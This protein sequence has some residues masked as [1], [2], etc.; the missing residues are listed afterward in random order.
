MKS[1][2][3]NSPFLY[4]YCAVE[5]AIAARGV[6]KLPH[7][8]QGS[9]PRPVAL[10]DRI[11]LIV[12]DVPAGE[13]EPQRVEARLT[14]LDWVSR[15]GAAHHAVAD[16]LATKHTVVPFR[17]FTLFSSEQRARS[18]LATK[19]RSIQAA[20]DRVRGK[21]EWVLRIGKPDPARAQSTPDT[22]RLATAASGTSFLAQK[23]AANRAKT[24]L[25]VRVRDDVVRV[26]DALTDV[27]DAARQ[28]PLDQ[29]TGAVLDAAFL[30]PARQTASFKRALQQ[31]ADGLL[32][33]G[34]RV[35]L[36]GPWPPYS[37]VSIAT[38]RHER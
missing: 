13:Y 23:A 12:A 34:C 22:A 10:N 17:L 25:A 27:S 33:A 37:F 29:T 32:R 38:K 11:T 30:V 31:S 21:A 9:P 8:P 35:S 1:A 15:C 14:D 18:T 4:V 20:L 19:A 16:A 28:R 6:A 5:G 36:T 7:L 2:A 24:D 26:Y 3:T